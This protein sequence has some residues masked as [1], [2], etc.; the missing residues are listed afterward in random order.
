MRQRPHRLVTR[1]HRR[2]FRPWPQ[3]CPEAIRQGSKFTYRVARWRRPEISRS[4]ASRASRSAW[5]SSRRVARSRVCS[6]ATISSSTHNH[7]SDRHFA[8][9]HSSPRNGQG[10]V[11]EPL[12][13][14]A[15][16]TDFSVSRSWRRRPLTSL[17]TS[18]STTATGP[19]INL[20][21]VPG[22]SITARRRERSRT[23]WLSRRELV[24][25]PRTGHEPCRRQG[26]DSDTARK[27]AG[28]SSPGAA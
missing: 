15:H 18:H 28:L 1:V 23:R 24:V 11:H 20:S 3:S 16:G 8:V 6:A 13:V 2:L 22:L 27:R 17:G 14:F 25:T 21:T 5:T 12:V 4:A 19:V 26:H 7:R 10:L 9:L